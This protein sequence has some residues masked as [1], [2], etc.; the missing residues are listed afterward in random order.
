M[1]LFDSLLKNIKRKPLQTDFEVNYFIE[2]ELGK[3]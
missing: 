3:G 1:G 2:K